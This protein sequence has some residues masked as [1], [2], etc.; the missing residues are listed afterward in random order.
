[1]QDFFRCAPGYE[2]QAEQ[3]QDKVYRHRL[4][5]LYHETRLQC[6]I[7]YSADVL[8]QVVRKAMPGLGRSPRTSTSW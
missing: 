4:S 7:N 1:M 3:V 6:I 2:G 8:G 5:D